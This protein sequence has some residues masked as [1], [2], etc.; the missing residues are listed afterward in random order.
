MC[1]KKGGTF[2]GMSLVA[3]SKME[4]IFKQRGLKLQEPHHSVHNDC[5]KIHF[6]KLSFNLVNHVKLSHYH[7]LQTS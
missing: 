4:G 7:K 6:A 2:I 5:S 3:S 1:S